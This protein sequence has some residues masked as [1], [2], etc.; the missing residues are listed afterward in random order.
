MKIAR[1][2]YKPAEALLLSYQDW[3]TIKNVQPKINN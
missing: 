1:P 3:Y 2:E